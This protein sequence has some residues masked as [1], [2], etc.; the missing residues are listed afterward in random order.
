M[1]DRPYDRLFRGLIEL[2]FRLRVMCDLSIPLIFYTF[3]NTVYDGLISL[4]SADI[5]Y[6]TSGQCLNLHDGF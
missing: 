4:T 5:D 3:Q 2:N 6:F 1:T